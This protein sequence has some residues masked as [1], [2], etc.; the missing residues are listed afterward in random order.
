ME[1][2]AIFGAAGAIGRTVGAELQRKGIQFRAVGR[3]RNRLEAA[4]GGMR[5]AEIY[6]ADITDLRSASA[7]ARGADTLIYTVGVPYTAFH[8][9]PKLMRT[10]LEAAAVVQIQRIVVVS[11]VYSY[12]VPQTKTVAE[13]HPRNPHTRKGQFRKEQ[14]D[15]ALEAQQKG[16]LQALVVRLPDFYGPF[17][18]NSLA[19]PIIHAAL[20]GR[21]AMWLGPIDAPHEFVFVP[22]VGPVIVALAARPDCY[23]EAW[24]YA[25]FGE[26]TARQF[27]TSVY[28]EVGREPKWRVAG[29]G[30]LRLAGFFQPMMRELREMYYLQ[31][32]P[33]I[34][35]DEKL[36]RK[37]GGASKTT[38]RDGIRQTI[39]WMR[40]E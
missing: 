38:Y 29:P 13:T 28:R 22:D 26:I 40:G 39:Q 2:V 27:I 25:G 35:D 20:K 21:P 24:N 31:E 7:A 1:K 14:E 23:G 30:L 17:A 11:S 19:N 4:F 3:A 18:D 33:V 34:L 6:A 32:R 37:L 36:M 9:H 8:L 10:T 15:L 12:G 16:V 5:H